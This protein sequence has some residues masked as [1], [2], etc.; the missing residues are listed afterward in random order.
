MATA[1][2]RPSGQGEGEAGEA[3]EQF[4][5][6][7]LLGALGKEAEYNEAP[8]TPAQE[9][10]FTERLL[11]TADEAELARVIGGIVNTVGRV[12]QGVQ[13]RRQLAAGP[14]DHRRRR[15]GRRGGARGRGRGPG[16]RD[17]VG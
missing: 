12:V 15:P 1:R 17:R 11:E 2:A 4:L 14:R 5:H 16:A 13:R 8:L 10:E 6:K 7:L 9:A 3:E